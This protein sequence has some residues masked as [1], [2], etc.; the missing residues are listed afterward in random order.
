MSTRRYIELVSSRRNRNEFPLPSFFEVPLSG[1]NLCYNPN[2]ALDPVSL[3][4]PV[5]M[6]N[7][8]SVF[9]P[10]LLNPS[11][12]I[13]NLGEN[14][15]NSSLQLDPTTVVADPSFTTGGLV[16]NN[17]YR[18]YN[19]LDGTKGY[20]ID[21]NTIGS[22]RKI[23][24]QDAND[25]E[26]LLDVPMP[27]TVNI[28]DQYN[29]V[30]ASAQTYGTNFTYIENTLVNPQ[31]YEMFGYAYPNANEIFTDYN[32]TM[33]RGAFRPGTA[34]QDNTP[35]SQVIIAHNA[36]RRYLRTQGQFTLD[37]GDYY[38]TFSIRKE[39]PSTSFQTSTN[40]TL[41]KIGYTTIVSGNT[42]TVDGL[43]PISHKDIPSYKGQYIFI[44]PYNSDPITFVNYPLN[45]NG[46]DPAARQAYYYRIIN[47]VGLPA[48]P[49]P[50][51]Q[52][53]FTLD[54]A[55]DSTNYALPLGATEPTRV[56]EVLP[57]SYDN[58]VPLNY[59]GS[60]VS[61]N[62]GVCYEIELVALT[63]PN[64]LLKSGSR[65]AFYS[66]VQVQLENVTSPEGGNKNIFYSNNPASTKCLF[67]A[68]VTDL[69]DPLTTPYV[70]LDGFGITQT[71]KFKPND[72]LRFRVFLPDGAPFEPVLPDYFSPVAPNPLLQISATFGIRRL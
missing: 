41:G 62:E 66:Y 72:T 13:F 71:V 61:Q 25:I 28:G 12:V 15:G 11:L 56:V 53:V 26:S 68:P 14:E 6:F 4:A 2:N 5:F 23:R 59:S 44:T 48:A 64:V 16:T 63:L 58:F 37:S 65:I 20:L 33:Q 70:R 36:D 60:I 43:T 18:A 29:L 57:I 35:Q 9:P 30:D 8:N 10:N 45:I 38:Q 24:G 19:T 1:S 54:R 32:L 47:A 7:L 67:I 42:L 31:P 69:N 27:L 22:V 46:V 51:T 50:P 40:A 52:V 34:L 39:K 17:L 55:I 3:S 21:D 49:A